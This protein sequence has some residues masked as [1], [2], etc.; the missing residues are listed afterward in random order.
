MRPNGLQ[1]SIVVPTYRRRDSLARCLAAIQALD[2]PRDRFEVLVVDDGS[3]DPPTDLVASFESSLDVQLLRA[4]H[5][6]PANAR[7]T[8]AHQARGRIL[9]FTDDDCLPHPGWLA[10][11]DRCMSERH[12]PVA[13]GGRVVNVLEED[14]YA[15]ASQGIVDFLY[16]YYGEH[17]APG[18]FFTS[19]NLAMPRAEFLAIGGFDDGFKR[20]AAEDRDLCERWRAAG[21]ELHFAPDAVVGHAHK[22]GFSRFNRQHFVY[23]RGAFDLHRSRARRGERP[24]RLEPVRFYLG[25]IRHPL[26]RSP[27]P[28]GVAL[29]ALH[30]WS[31]AAYASG[32]FYE[33]IRRGWVVRADDQGAR[34][35]DGEPNDARAARRRSMSGAA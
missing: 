35:H 9:V 26:R 28:R 15:A 32:Y 7:N 25:L 4:R 31:Q 22:L 24:L 29:A 14:V 19:N 8:G 16:E 27:G 17:P 12:D 3:D 6:G 34:P 13:V 33:R 5:G 10:A 11:I 30:A 23:G 18:R 21:F 2:F 20:V 1:Y